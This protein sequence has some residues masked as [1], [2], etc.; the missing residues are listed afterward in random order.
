ML[1]A[2]LRHRSG[3][4]AAME[5]VDPLL[6]VLTH[7]YTGDVPVDFLSDAARLQ[8]LSFESLHRLDFKLAHEAEVRYEYNAPPRNIHKSSQKNEGQIQLQMFQATEVQVASVIRSA[9][10][11][12]VASVCSRLVDLILDQDQHRRVVD[13][14]H[15]IGKAYCGILL[16]LLGRSFDDSLSQEARTA[17]LDE[18]AT[19]L[20]SGRPHVLFQRCRVPTKGG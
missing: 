3:P 11:E 2:V 20:S 10:A 17:F 8:L 16:V 15:T 4:Q 5:H 12:A 9:G 6:A 7:P 19:R 18:L 14:I 13:D 1:V